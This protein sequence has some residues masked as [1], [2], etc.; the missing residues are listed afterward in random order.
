[1]SNVK[2]VLALVAAL[3][4]AAGS[5]QAAPT[6]GDY[7]RA[8]QVDDVAAVKRMVAGQID[9]NGRDED[10]GETGMIVAL[11]EDAMRVFDALLAHPAI[12]LEARA[13]N[14]NTALMMAAFKRNKAAVHALLAKGAAVNQDGWAAL[15]YAAAAGDVEIIATLL[16][17]GARIDST[18]PTGITPLMLA[19][20]EGQE[21]AV[22][23]LL[24]RGAS[25]TL[26]DAQG[27]TAVQIAERADKAY[28]VRAIGKHGK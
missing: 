5:A 11:R 3:L 13:R 6:S 10:R 19:A 15:H 21:D 28:I 26:A 17:R 24:E 1:M 20:R 9:P 2:T 14:G 22:V 12:D 7:F 25:T 8:V 23:A 4:L 18:S 27:L 16:E